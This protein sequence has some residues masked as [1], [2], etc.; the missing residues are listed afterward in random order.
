MKLLV[1]THAFL[2]LIVNDPRLAASA[3][4]IIADVG[5]D[6][7]LSAA[8][9]WE[10]AIKV[11]SGKLSITDEPE[12]YLVRYMTLYRVR[13]LPIEVGHAVHTYR[14]PLLHRD[15]F[16]RLLVAQSQMEGVPLLTDDLTIKQYPVQS[17]W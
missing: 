14:L 7:Y 16:D 8:S 13:P 4:R 1:D 5:N 11:R 17:V 10:F 2:W 3:R 6:L 9:A 12:S 15:P